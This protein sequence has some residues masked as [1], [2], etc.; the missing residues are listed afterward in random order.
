MILGL[1]PMFE[2]DLMPSHDEESLVHVEYLA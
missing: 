1:V 2:A